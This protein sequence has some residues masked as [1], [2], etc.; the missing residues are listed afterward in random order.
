M[1]GP[2]NCPSASHEIQDEHHQRHD[3]QQ[4]NETAHGVARNESDQPQDQQNYKNRPKHF[5]F[6]LAFSDCQEERATDVP[7]LTSQQFALLQ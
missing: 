4:V 6:L 2:L 3:Q 7:L 5:R 1:A